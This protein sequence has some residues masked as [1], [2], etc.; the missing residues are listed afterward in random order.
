MYPI[1]VCIHTPLAKETLDEG[2]GVSF[3]A[4]SKR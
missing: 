2:E 3:V 1:P 4:Q